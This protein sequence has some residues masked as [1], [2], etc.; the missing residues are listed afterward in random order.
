[1]Y[2]VLEIG[3]LNA[4]LRI[5]TLLDKHSTLIVFKSF[6]KIEKP[7]AV[8]QKK[9]IKSIFS[10]IQIKTYYFQQV[11]KVTNLEQF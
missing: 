6:W 2:A 3:N 8:F 4:K 10:D 11:K 9:V 1:M 7:S 5:R